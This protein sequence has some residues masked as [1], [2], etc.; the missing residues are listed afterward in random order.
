MRGAAMRT[1]KRNKQPFYYCLLKDSSYTNRISDE[2]GNETGELANQYEAPVL[3]YGNISPATG[4]AVTE[5]FG[6]LTDYDKVIVINDVDCPICESTVLFV[7]KVPED[8]S[9][10]SNEESNTVLGNDQTVQ[11]YE[12]PQYYYIV[13]RVSKS[14]NSVSIAIRKVTI[15]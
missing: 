13:R 8:T 1:L 10:E 3:M 6:E 15:Q 4:Q 14:L 5:Q 7:D 9:T 2:Y 11:E 12:V